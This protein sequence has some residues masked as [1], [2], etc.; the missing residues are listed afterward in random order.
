MHYNW[1]TKYNDKWGRNDTTVA[2]TYEDWYPTVD[3]RLELSV[4]YV[5]SPSFIRICL[6]GGDDFGMEKD[7]FASEKTFEEVLTEADNIP[8]PV[9]IEW[10]I[11]NG[12]ERA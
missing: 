12:F 8:E 11:L 7:Y 3:G 9:T 2:S 1:K 10:L 6:W 5:Y 4:I